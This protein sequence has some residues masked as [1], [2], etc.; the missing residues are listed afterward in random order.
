MRVKS[1]TEQGEPSHRPTPRSQPQPRTNNRHGQNQ[2]QTKIQ[3]DN[4]R[5]VNVPANRG[6]QPNTNTQR[7]PGP[8]RDPS[9]DLSGSLGSAG[10]IGTTPRAWA[11][12]PPSIPTATATATGPPVKKR[13]PAPLQLQPPP[14]SSIT[15]EVQGAQGA[16]GSVPP[17]MPT[18]TGP[19]VKKR[20]PPPLQ[21]QQVPRNSTNSGEVRG[22]SGSAPSVPS[23]TSRMQ[24]FQ[25]EHHPG[26]QNQNSNE[27]QQQ[28]PHPLLRAHQTPNP[29]RQEQKKPNRDV[30]AIIEQRILAMVSVGISPR[31]NEE[32]RLNIQLASIMQNLIDAGP[33]G[34]SKLQ[35][36]S[37]TRQLRT[38]T[39]RDIGLGCI[40]MARR[41]FS[42]YIFKSSM[43]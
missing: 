18:A 7:G 43:S 42:T 21:L 19:P 39:F 13:R 26:H 24:P 22:T 25:L 27:S 37:A 9:T 35:G 14:Q 16:P 1:S 12:L 4:D 3:N 29:A 20:R 34:P 40:K 15:S 10:Q 38:P 6:S 36:E 5:L 33:L 8:G 41:G 11:Q 30:L 23:D 31:Y 2:N 17:H 28:S 32:L